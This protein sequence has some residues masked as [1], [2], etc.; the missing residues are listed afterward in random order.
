MGAAQTSYSTFDPADEAPPAVQAY[1]APPDAAAGSA[2]R[3]Q[4]AY[5]APDQLNTS[6]VRS[7]LHR[8]T[9]RTHSSAFPRS[10]LC[11]FASMLA[12]LL[13]LVPF[14]SIHT[15]SCETHSSSHLFGLLSARPPDSA[16]LI[17]VADSRCQRLLSGWC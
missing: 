1:A 13:L 17:S 15:A 7:P 14:R 8:H 16:I 6:L 3:A 12:S 9:Y 2:S 10:T 5:A 11:G 4:S